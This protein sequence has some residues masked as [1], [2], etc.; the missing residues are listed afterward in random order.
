[1]HVQSYEYTHHWKHMSTQGSRGWP[2][3]T[4]NTGFIHRFKLLNFKWDDHVFTAKEQHWRVKRHT[5]WNKKFTKGLTCNL[6]SEFIKTVQEFQSR[7]FPQWKIT[8]FGQLIG[9]PL[10]TQPI[11]LTCF[12]SQSLRNSSSYHTTIIGQKWLCL[13]RCVPFL[14]QESHFVQFGLVTC[15]FYV[16]GTPWKEVVSPFFLSCH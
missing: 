5:Q 6:S 10:Q 11:F 12:R 16:R 9:L 13:I 8:Q 15:L 4:I 3:T 1:M 14:M 7:S 2:I